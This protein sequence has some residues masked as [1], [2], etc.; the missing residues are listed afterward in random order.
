MPINCSTNPVSG[1]VSCPEIP[2][3]PA[4]PGSVE[5]APNLGWNAGANWHESLAGNVR[6][7]NIKVA[8]GVAGAVIGLRNS[9]EFPEKPELV[10]HGLAFMAFEGVDAFRVIERGAYKTGAAE[11]G[12]NDNFEIR[13]TGGAVT[14]YRNGELVYTSS[15]PSAGAVHL[16]SCLY[17]GGDRLGASSYVAGGEGDEPPLVFPGLSGSSESP[18]TLNFTVP[19]GG[20]DLTF[21]VTPEPS[22]SGSVSFGMKKG[23]MPDPEHPED[24]DAF[25]T[26]NELV[27]IPGDVSGTWYVMILPYDTPFSG[28]TATANWTPP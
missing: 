2:E 27:E 17:A 4:V 25:G 19:L 23:A 26:E 16:T 18:A 21:I 14:Y 10:Q 22:A 3:V 7:R 24:I 5:L 15:L 20:M 11:R 13:R 1:C 12:P 6:A 8:P 9:R 28:M